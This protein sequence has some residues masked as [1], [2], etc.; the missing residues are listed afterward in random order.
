MKTTIVPITEDNLD[1]V[2]AA[3]AKFGMPRSAGWLR[4]CFFDP[5]VE[6]LTRDRIRGHMAVDENG[7]AIA[8]H[9]YYYQPC[10]FRQDRFLAGTGAIMGAKAKYGEELLCVQDKNKETRTK[11]RLGFGNCIYGK[12]AYTVNKKVYKMN[13]PPYRSGE[14]RFCVL[15]CSAYLLAILWRIRLRSN[16]LNRLVYLILRPVAWIVRAASNL[17]FDSDGYSYVRKNGFEDARFDDFWKRF[18]AGNDGVISSREPKRMQWLFHDSIKAG[19]VF[20]ATAEKNGCIEGYVLIRE[21]G[22]GRCPKSFDIVDICAIGNNI[23][24]LKGLCFEAKR[25]AAEKGGI[26]LYFSGSMPNQEKWLDQVFRYRGKDVCY[27]MFGTK[28]LEIAESLKQ[29]K[30]WFFGPFDGERCLGHGGYIDM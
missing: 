23:D 24:C 7:E 21:K 28:D 15:D 27:F 5:T 26:K 14:Y 1:V 30:G 29:N 22:E 12:R 8:I 18:L 9:G 6:D 20:L 3:A 16:I 13:E 4:R 2:A 25:L 11:D 10:Y 17:R 19:K